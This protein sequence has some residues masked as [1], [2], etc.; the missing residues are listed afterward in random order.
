MRFIEL[1][2][3]NIFSI[4]LSTVLNILMVSVFLKWR[5]LH[6]RLCF[7]RTILFIITLII[8]E[9]VIGAAFYIFGIFSWKYNI[10]TILME[11]IILAGNMFTLW[12]LYDKPLQ[13]SWMATIFLSMIDTFTTELVNAFIPDVFFRLDDLKERLLYFFY[14]WGIIPVIEILVIFLCNRVSMGR[15]IRHW[16]DMA[17]LHFKS[18][19]LLSLYPVLIKGIQLLIQTLGKVGDK[20]AIISL[21]M[22]FIIY[23]FFMY[24]RHEELQK[25]KL[26]IQ[27]VS[28][29]QQNSY[30]ENLENLQKEMRRFRHDYKNM[31][32]GM[33]LQAKEGGYGSNPEFYS[34]YDSKF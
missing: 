22:L 34:G 6:G 27:Q 2:Y 10:G 5:F 28:L 21:M 13:S 31:M 19:A 33:Y 4:L 25:Q 15:V 7:C 12:R 17:N 3:G 11:Y 24:I 20:N 30:I 23:I 26:E 8:M 18:I 14:L 16:I 9:A 29:Q 1:V 32:S